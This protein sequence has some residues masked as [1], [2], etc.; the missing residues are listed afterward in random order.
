MR[1]NSPVAALARIAPFPSN[2]PEAVVEAEIVSDGVLP[3]TFGAAVEGKV[4]ADVPV[5]VTQGHP[6]VWG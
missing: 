4:L 5:D 6:P 3:A 1:I 2:A